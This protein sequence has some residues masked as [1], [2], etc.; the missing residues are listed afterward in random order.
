MTGFRA[1]KGKNVST[2]LPQKNQ[3]SIAVIGMACRVP[4]ARNINELWENLARG[5]ESITTFGREDQLAKGVPAEMVDNP[6]YVSAA[7]VLEGADEF[8]AGFFGMSPREAEITDPQ[9]RL[10][11]ELS[12][13]ALED[14]GYDPRNYPGSVGVYG[15][16]GPDTYR[17]R[18]VERNAAILDAANWMAV[19]VGNYPDL[20][21]TR[22][23]YKLG[24]RGPSYDLQT[25]CSTS[26]V[27]LHVACEALLREDCDIA[28]AGGAMIELPQG[29]GYLHDGGVES[30]DGHCRPFDARA[31]GT[32]WS[33][34]GGMVV[35]KRLGDALRDGDTIRAVVRGTAINNDGATKSGI[36]APSVTGQTEAARWALAR[37]GVD[38]RSVGYVEAHG[39]GTL[40]GDP[41]EVAG[42]KRVYGADSDDS[43]WCLLGSVKSNVGHLSQAAG[44]VGVI[45]TVLALENEQIPPTVH[46]TEA[47][48]GLELANSPFRVAAA[49]EPWPS[50]GQPRRAGV[51]SFGIGGTNAHAILEEAP[52]PRPTEITRERHLLQVSARTPEALERA[53][54]DLGA[55]G[56]ERTGLNAADVSH[57]L[58]AGRAAHRHRA[59]AVTGSDAAELSATLSD[60]SAWRTGV[61]GKTR[62]DVAFLF[63]GQG[64]QY[65]GMA[66][67]LHAREPVFRAAVDAC[68]AALEPEL[69]AGLREL[70][71]EGAGDPARLDRTELAQP[72]LFAV[73]YALAALWRSWG[74]EPG[75]MIGHSVGEYVAAVLAGVFT[76]PDAVRLVARRGALMQSLPAGAML[77]V[78]L[79]DGQELGDLP[80]ALSVACFN[81]PGALVVS[82]PAEPVDAF[83]RALAERGV[84]AGR[85]HTSHAFHSAMMEPILAEFAAEVVAV[86]RSAPAKRYLS[87]V[88]GTW[89][90]PEQATDPAYWAEHLRRP[91]RFADCVATL[92]AEGRW[93]LVECGPG[94][95]LANLALTQAPE[96][97]APVVTS[98]PAPKSAVDAATTIATAAGQLWAAGLPLDPETF[99]DP[100]RRVPLPTYPF[101]RQ[102]HWAVPDT[103]EA[104]GTG[105]RAVDDA[106]PRPVGE[107][108]HTETW[109]QDP[110]PG[111]RDSVARRV[112]FG[113]DPRAEEIGAELRRQGV[114]VC[115]VGTGTSYEKADATHY[116]IDPSD[117][118][119]YERLLRDLG[120][121]GLPPTAI[122]HAWS[123]SLP[124]AAGNPEATER[125][126]DLGFYSLMHLVQALASAGVT[127][128]VHIDVLTAG[129]QDVVGGD[130]GRPEQA[131]VAGVA[132][133]LPL[134]APQFSVRH[135]DLAAEPERGDGAGGT[136]AEIRRLP[137]RSETVALRNRRRWTPDYRPLRLEGAPDD[138]GSRDGGPQGGG[139]EQGGAEHGLEEG[140]AG[141]GEPTGLRRGGVYLITGGLGGIGLTLAEDL[142]RR[143]GAK[144]VLTSRIGLPPRRTWDRYVAARG[145][146]DRASRAIDAVRRIEAAGA[147]VLVVA[148]DVTSTE[149]MREVRQQILDTFGS[150]DGVVHAAGVPTGALLEIQDPKE[151]AEV[152]APKLRGTLVLHEV[153]RDLAP[154][155]LLL[156]SSIT[157]AFGRLGHADYCAGNS[158][159]DA[160]A[161]SVDGGPTRVLSVG[162]DAWLDIGM[163]VDRSEPANLR[164]A[165]HAARRGVPLDTIPAD[166]PDVGIRPADGVEAFRTLVGSG[167]R[168]HVLTTVLPAPAARAGWQVDV[169]VLGGAP[170][171]TTDTGTPDAG[172][173]GT[174][175]A[176]ADG[177]ADGSTGAGLEQTL[178]A[179]WADTLGHPKIGLDQDFVELGGDSLTAIRLLSR[180]RQA[181]RVNLPRRSLFD[182]STVRELAALIGTLREQGP[183]EAA[184][185]TPAPATTITRVA[186]PRG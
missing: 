66:A 108:F 31:N 12:H 18:N 163:A 32:V 180:I 51:S 56:R 135:I 130:L 182:A 60:R 65:A 120:A 44:V 72:A 89:V 151:S 98:L 138:G 149:D 159:L 78:R 16:C 110:S 93:A 61:A 91:V 73:E 184:A 171:I 179:I 62:P 8:D 10:F 160:Y 58:R 34:G 142:A 96:D 11:L 186:R 64:S 117:A 99:G 131:T 9:Q 118:G 28:L 119:H 59:F 83:S 13:T 121:S 143:V 35:L 166:E 57:T 152:L 41:V 70:V 75:A 178:A 101:E 167:A 92:H 88:T 43:G 33:S 68:L 185:G 47:N 157:A 109:S 112:L 148:A 147:E 48:P 3:E 170:A 5:R 23:S 86:T 79:D 107:W 106:T 136:V 183:Q 22:V 122:V 113:A 145:A 46:F 55:H 90:T 128:P 165:R 14:A 137:D 69:A 181:T 125:A 155:F 25:S 49:L 124:P 4:G 105:G 175:T 146:D 54:G 103:V 7:P 42:L 173:E 115:H 169:T 71:V 37:A 85:L 15:G 6:A 38:P 126:Q 17:W 129:A 84:A 30:M 50:G 94:R 156:C 127:D 162:W 21:T 95:Q 26:L 52:A 74:V 29:V 132:K 77:S 19:S 168:A 40:V 39:T 1:A 150:L 87:N 141:A 174:G 164:R 80:D 161:R 45:K 123:L 111:K 158:F 104:P 63:S 2:S 133:V 102:R 97:A 53:L 134:E 67:D 36:T 176:T 100:G 116:R 81:A 82:G 76:L 144:L 172:A 177:G 20:L 24:L 139:A 27:A 154:D 114:D 153:L 140:A